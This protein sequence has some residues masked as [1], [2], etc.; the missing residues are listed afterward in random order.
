MDS[1]IASRSHAAVDHA[2]AAVFR[3][4]HIH[5]AGFLAF[6]DDFGLGYLLTEHFILGKDNI[7]TIL[8]R[9]PESFFDYSGKT[10]HCMVQAGIHIIAVH[11]ETGHYTLKKSNYMDKC[12]FAKSG[13]FRTH[14]H[15]NFGKTDI[16]GGVEH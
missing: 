10:G 13:I 11:Q 3:I 4:E 5:Q 15:I 8:Q 7:N 2:I 1:E 16:S 6:H 9:I 12:F 14:F